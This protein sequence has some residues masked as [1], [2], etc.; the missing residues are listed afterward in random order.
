MKVDYKNADLERME[1]DKAFTARFEA[2]IVRSFR[3]RMQYIRNA[4]DER[5]LYAMKSFHFEKLK[6]DRQHQRSIRLNNKWRLILEIRD[7]HNGNITTIVDIEDY[8]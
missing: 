1:A 5:D 7:D 6:G 3:M 4:K 2:A 8:H